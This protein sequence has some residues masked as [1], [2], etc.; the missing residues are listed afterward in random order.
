MAC[1][2]TVG[3]RETD[4]LDKL[5]LSPRTLSRG[6]G[7]YEAGNA[8]RCYVKLF[9]TEAGYVLPVNHRVLSE[10]DLLEVYEQGYSDGLVA[11]SEE[12]HDG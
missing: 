2:N 1:G 10:E 12:V 8:E 7:I 3:K 11:R 4:M 9:V 6:C 5:E